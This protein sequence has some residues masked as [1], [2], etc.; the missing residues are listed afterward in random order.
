M[1]K[2]P[3]WATIVGVLGIIFACFGILGAG[4]DI[5]MPKMMDIQKEIFSHMEE[6]QKKA[7]EKEGSENVPDEEFFKIFKSMEKMW[8]TPEWFGIWSIT[9][10]I[11]KLE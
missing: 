7:A 1:K 6:I 3:T 8:E 4:Y 9:T 5:I 10:G 11:I 2:R